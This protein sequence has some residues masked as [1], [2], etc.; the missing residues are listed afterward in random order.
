[1]WGETKESAVIK[2]SEMIAVGDSNWD[3]NQK[4][5]RDWSGFIGMYEERQ[6]PLEVHNK[7]AEILYCDGHV[8]T[9][10]RL[11]MIGQLLKDTGSRQEVARQWN[12]DNLPHFQ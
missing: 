3:L 8:E 7:R 1:M 2:P 6:W 5:D 12:R 9:K 4:G 11:D 10:R